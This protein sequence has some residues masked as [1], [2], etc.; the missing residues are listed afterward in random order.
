MNLSRPSPA[1]RQD[2][3]RGRFAFS[4]VEVALALGILSFALVG[5]M[6]I[7]P[8]G[9][10]TFHRSTDN[11][12]GAQIAQR[13]INEAGQTDFSTL[14]GTVASTPVVRYFDNE[15]N[16]LP[17]ANKSQAVFNTN[18]VVTSGTAGTALPGG[19]A[20][21]APNANLATVVV[22]V[23][24]NPGNRSLTAGPNQLWAATAGVTIST[25][26]ANVARND[27]TNAASNQ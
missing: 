1:T 8:V 23:A 22:Q 3:A 14:V 17:A 15:G 24:V 20:A 27:A 25:Y 16:E 26:A 13:L 6:G 19:A 2:D 9:L 5:L 4:L 18:L 12:T 11:S 10:S 21:T 7:L